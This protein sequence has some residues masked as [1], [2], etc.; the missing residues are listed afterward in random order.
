MM[1]QASRNDD[2]VTSAPRCPPRVAPRKKKVSNIKPP[3]TLSDASVNKNDLVSIDGS[4]EDKNIN[5]TA[6]GKDN[7]ETDMSVGDEANH[8]ST[9][10]VIPI[11]DSNN[12]FDDSTNDVAV[13]DVFDDSVL[14]S[15]SVL[16]ESNHQAKENADTDL[17][18]SV[19]TENKVDIPKPLARATSLPPNPSFNRVIPKP[20]FDV[21]HAVDTNSNSLTEIVEEP[22][23]IRISQKLPRKPPPKPKAIPPPKPKLTPPPPQSRSN[24]VNSSAE[25]TTPQSSKQVARKESASKKIDL[26]KKKSL[27]FKE[28]SLKVFKSRTSQSEPDDL[29]DAANSDNAKPTLSDSLVSQSPSSK[30]EHPK[31]P[32]NAKPLQPSKAYPSSAEK[33]K[34]APPP[35]PALPSVMKSRRASVPLIHLST[36]AVKQASTP[37]PPIPPVESCET[38]IYNETEDNTTS[39]FSTSNRASLSSQKSEKIP[40]TLPDPDCEDVASPT[41]SDKNAFS[42]Q[43]KPAKPARP[44]PMQLDSTMIIV[45][46]KK[47]A[48]KSTDE[49]ASILEL[50]KG[51]DDDKQKP[52]IDEKMKDYFSGELYCIAI[53]DYEPS[54]FTDLSFTAGER[55]FVLRQLGDGMLFGRNENGEEGA[56]PGKYV[57]LEDN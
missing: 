28:K 4:I 2:S 27:Q 10:N 52:E 57:S 30:T 6:N 9:A 54:N 41:N 46:A 50:L 40:E 1:E 19:E 48:E 20:V 45:S 13:E 36:N 32:D 56:F 55:V 24:E 23:G 15:N 7:V 31:K 43:H 8:V 21:Q 53:E 22:T 34:R 5:G 38:K 25:K 17:H 12:A 18:A 49:E 47:K 29:E 11:Q 44:P 42:P 16:S 51:K 3:V 35:R 37:K 26:I 14:Q 33:S 39:T